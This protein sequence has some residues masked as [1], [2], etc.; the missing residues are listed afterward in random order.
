VRMSHHH[1]PRATCSGSRPLGHIR[2]EILRKLK[3][4]VAPEIFKL[5]TRQIAVPEYRDLRRLPAT[6][7][8]QFRVSPRKPL[9]VNMFRRHAPIAANQAPCPLVTRSRRFP[10]GG[11]CHSGD[12]VESR[13]W[14]THHAGSGRARR[15]A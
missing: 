8:P 12:S 5:L 1:R 2:M 7:S 13:L 14:R 6:D 15:G 9:L 10:Q 4:A 11:A 3:R